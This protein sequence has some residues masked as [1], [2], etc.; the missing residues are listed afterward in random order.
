M[1]LHHKSGLAYA[2]QYAAEIL[3]QGI[4]VK[5]RDVYKENNGVSPYIHSYSTFNR[6]MGIAKEFINFAKARGINK[7]NKLDS[8]VVNSFINEKIGKGYSQKTIKV[9]LSALGK[10]FAVVNREDLS[11]H[12]K[13]NYA[14]FYSSASQPGRALAFSNPQAVI[15]SLKDPVYQAMAIVQYFSGARIG[16][17]KKM[18]IKDTQLLFSG[19]KGGKDRVID[20]SDR[21]EKLKIIRQAKE[22]IDKAIEEKGWKSMRKEYYQS[23]KQACKKTGEIYTGAHAFRVNYIKERVNELESKGYSH[24]EAL[25]IA[26]KETGH[27]RVSI[28]SYYYG[29]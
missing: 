21:T 3:K 16:D 19:S 27:N 23:L 13:N 11:E 15:Q 24:K 18:H 22:V 6:Y 4:G 26:S 8:D 25:K 20:F 17:I 10:F 2:L 1:G 7:L 28:T 14:D 5:K 12:I 29:G 9:N